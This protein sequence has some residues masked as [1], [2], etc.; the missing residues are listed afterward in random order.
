M[1]IAFSLS[2]K[3][4]S[5]KNYT[6]WMYAANNNIHIINMNDYSIEEFNDVLK[7]CVG[8]VFTGGPDVHPSYYNQESRIADCKVDDLRDTRE[9][10]MMEICCSLNMPIL[11]ISGLLL[12]PAHLCNAVEPSSSCQSRLAPRVIRSLTM[13][14][15]GSSFCSSL[16]ISSIIISPFLFEGVIISS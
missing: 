8:I 13:F 10:K 16:L 1:N 5:S 4:K 6:E 7:T 3:S 11:A 14:R 9:I 12:L 2:S 15:F